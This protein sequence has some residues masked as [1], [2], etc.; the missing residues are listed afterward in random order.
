KNQPP[1]GSPLRPRTPNYAKSQNSP[2]LRS[3]LEQLAFLTLRLATGSKRLTNGGT[4]K[5]L[6]P[7][8]S[9]EAVGRGR[10]A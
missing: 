4:K 3:K 6:Y 1:G 5:D 10:R 2:S 7:P 9:F 8:R